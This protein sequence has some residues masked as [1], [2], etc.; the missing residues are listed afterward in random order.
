MGL[1][2]T[3]WAAQFREGLP[4]CKATAPPACCRGRSRR[5]LNH[6]AHIELTAAR[7]AV[8]HLEPVCTAACFGS[9]WRDEHC[10]PR[11]LC[12]G[13]RQVGLG[14][15][16]AVGAGCGSG[17]SP[18]CSTSLA[19]PCRS[20]HAASM[21]CV[22]TVIEEAGRRLKKLKPPTRHRVAMHR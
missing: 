4:A 9:V 6:E 22:L 19:G 5:Y 11:L 2:W 20:Y 15:D 17:R 21:L 8:R 13:L 14:V 7:P 3:T 1:A 12:W 16:L 18:I 10:L